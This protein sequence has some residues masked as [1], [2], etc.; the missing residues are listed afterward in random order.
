MRP[1]ERLA[2]TLLGVGIAYAYGLA[3]PRTVAAILEVFQE[4]DGS[5][6]VPEP[7]Q[8]RLGGRISAE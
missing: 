1:A 4:R 5:V 2:E 7:L 6:R 3:L 8:A